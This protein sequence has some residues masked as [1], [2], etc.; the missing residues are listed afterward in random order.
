MTERQLLHLR[1]V[2]SDE[3]GGEGKEGNSSKSLFDNRIKLVEYKISWALLGSKLFS[4]SFLLGSSSSF[5]AAAAASE[6]SFF[7]PSSLLK[8]AELLQ[9]PSGWLHAQN[10][11]WTPP[12]QSIDGNGKSLPTFIRQT[13]DWHR[14]HINL[15]AFFEDVDDELFFIA[16]DNPHGNR[17]CF[18]T[19]FWTS[20]TLIRVMGFSCC[21]LMRKKA[22]SLALFLTKLWRLSHDNLPRESH[23]QSNLTSFLEVFSI[24]RI[25]FPS[26]DI[27]I[28]LSRSQFGI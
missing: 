12:F 2:L 20:L 26:G 25:S 5:E 28:E 11:S 16:A 19:F 13:F 10:H 23:G 15:T 21:N 9:S 6:T 27:V 7:F 8:A 17:N 22:L 3:E 14:E 4:W 1:I 18:F 24:Q